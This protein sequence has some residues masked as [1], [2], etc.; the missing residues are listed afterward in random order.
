MKKIMFFVATFLLV[1]IFT[2]FAHAQSAQTE[3]WVC[4]ESEHC[5]KDP[6]SCS[7]SDGH[8]ARLTAKSGFEPLT[9]TP[10]YIVECVSTATSQICTTGSE[11]QDMVVYKQS[12][13]ATLQTDLQYVFEGLFE[14]NG[15]TPASNP[16]EW[17]GA[18]EWKDSTPEGHDRRWYAMNYWDPTT[19]PI[20]AAGGQQQ[21]TF[22]FETAEKDCAKI[23][24]DPYGRVFDAGTLEP[25]RGSKVTL[26]IKKGGTFVD[27]T[28]LD[29]PGGNI[30]N[31]QTV[32]EDGAFSFVVPDGEYRLL[33]NPVPLVDANI[34]DPNYAKAYSDIYLVQNEELIEQ[35][36]EIVHRDIAVATLNTNNPVKMME[37]FY[38]STP[39]GLIIIDGQVSHPLTKLNAKMNFVST[40][41][42]SSVLKF[43]S[44]AFG[45]FNIEIDQ[46]SF[47]KDPK[48]MEIFSELEL[49]KVDLRQP[50]TKKNGIVKSVSAAQRD[51]SIVKF[52]PIPQ[53]LEGVAYD[54]G[55]KV[56]P[57][58]AVGVYLQFSNKAYSQKTADNNGF[59]KFSSEYLPSF[60]YEIRYTTADGKVINTKPSVFLAQNQKYIAEQQ[61]NP[62]VGKDAKNNIAPTLSPKK[63]TPSITKETSDTIDTTGAGAGAKV[64]QKD[65]KITELTNKIFIQAIFL[66]LALVIL[67]GVSVWLVIHFKKTHGPPSTM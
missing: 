65:T 26:Q 64:T 32:K 22:D 17:G 45:R 57:N 27:M 25:V 67:I 28:A 23:A 15:S 39:Q 19:A 16:T 1:C 51:N 63:N 3:R 11:A 60:P 5:W 55:G 49:V 50:I 41:L 29:L 34:I 10:T 33:S 56:I 58:A 52:E 18:Y 44:D 2:P 38:R 9:G 12:N 46:N 43:Q 14:S 48:N 42:P 24:W 4:L 8:R 7:V 61:I 40:G 6:N 62:F 53:Y 66:I 35:Q 13:I 59:F 54:A 31:P 37:Y 36:G 20:G 30:Q 47:K 21:G